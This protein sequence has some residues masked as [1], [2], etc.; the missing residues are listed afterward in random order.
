M[1]E[2][3]YTEAL[4]EALH[5]EMDRDETVIVIGEDVAGGAGT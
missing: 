3:S 2:K 5:Q 4:N 1:P